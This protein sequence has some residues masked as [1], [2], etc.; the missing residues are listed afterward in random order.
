MPP[1]PFPWDRKDFFRDKKHAGGGGYDR[2]SEPLGGGGGS[3]ARWRDT[4]SHG[5]RN[6]YARWNFPSSDF[7]RPPG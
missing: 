7:R 6:E 3:V 1:E 5:S 2:A 4:P